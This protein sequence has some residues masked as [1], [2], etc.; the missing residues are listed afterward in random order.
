VK[1]T[2]GWPR[3]K[4]LQ[5]RAALN[6]GAEL[7]RTAMKPKPARKDPLEDQARALVSQRSGGRCE[8]CGSRPASNFHH[9]QNRSASGVWSAENGMALCGSGTTFC[10]G[11]VTGN[12]RRAREQGWSV[13][14]WADPARIPAWI[15]GR[16]FVLLTPTG[17]YATLEDEVA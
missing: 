14:S 10:H 8:I 17:D 16:E 12:P 11:F 15:F 5:A 9:R 2:G 13:P 1:R 6:R 4:R 3:K 7:T